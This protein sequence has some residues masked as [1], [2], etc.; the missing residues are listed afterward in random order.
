MTRVYVREE[1]K[2]GEKDLVRERR[3]EWK[4]EKWERNR[5]WGWEGDKEKKSKEE[6]GRSGV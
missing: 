3:K 6:A 2:R 1:G 5:Q 4:R